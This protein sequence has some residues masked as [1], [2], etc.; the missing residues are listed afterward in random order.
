MTLTH[1]A[2]AVAQANTDVITGGSFLD[3]RRRST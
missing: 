2:V 1:K 3:P